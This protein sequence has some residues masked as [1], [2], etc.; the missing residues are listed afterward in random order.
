[1]VL[2][3]LI[4]QISECALLADGADATDIRTRL[5]PKNYLDCRPSPI[6]KVFDSISQ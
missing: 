1:M 4:A 5:Q 2:V 3:R 6:L